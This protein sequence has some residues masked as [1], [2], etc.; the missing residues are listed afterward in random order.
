MG[1][2]PKFIPRIVVLGSLRGAL[3]AVYGLSIKNQVIL[4]GRKRIKET[5][6]RKTNRLSWFAYTLTFPMILSPSMRFLFPMKE[7][8]ASRVLGIK[9]LA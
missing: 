8:M 9:S 1:R 6:K 2:I 3:M 7:S 5:Q 4:L